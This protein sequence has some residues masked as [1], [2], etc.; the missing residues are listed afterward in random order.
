MRTPSDQLR[1]VLGHL[2]MYLREVEELL[3][4]LE[5]AD[6][7]LCLDTLMAGLRSGEGFADGTESLFANIAQQF[8]SLFTPHLGWLREHK[9]FDD[10][11]YTRFWP[12]RRADAAEIEAQFRIVQTRGLNIATRNEAWQ[13]LLQTRQPAV[14]MRLAPWLSE[15]QLPP[16]EDEPPGLRDLL[17]LGD[18]ALGR[19]QLLDARSALNSIN[20]ELNGVG[21]HFSVDKGLHRL[22]HDPVWHIR[23]PDEYFAHNNGYYPRKKSRHPDWALPTEDGI[24]A[25]VG[26]TLDGDCGLCG[27]SLVRLLETPAMPAGMPSAGQ[28]L[29]LAVCSSCLGWDSPYLHYRHDSTGTPHCLHDGPHKAPEFPVA[30]FVATPVTLTPTPER[31]RQQDWAYSHG[32]NLNRLGGEPCWVQSADYPPCPFCQQPMTHLAQFDSWLPTVDGKEFL[33]GSG[34]LAYVH[35]CDNCRVSGW[36]WQCT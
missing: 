11:G 28:P 33:W 15:P 12:W 20:S 6:I 16:D 22:C 14:L 29:T 13:R 1:H 17:A 9:V 26:G 7:A 30:P 19:Y 21:Y 10:S 18:E 36:L 34:G 27:Q 5:L 2:F 3:P 8:P 4:Q 35:W 23:F 32:S 25:K 31:F 24:A